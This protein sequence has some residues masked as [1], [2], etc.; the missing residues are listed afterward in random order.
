MGLAFGSRSEE[1]GICLLNMFSMRLEM[2]LAFVFGRIFGVVNLLYKWPSQNFTALP[3]I[4]ML[5][6][7]VI[8]R[9][10]MTKFIGILI[11]FEQLK[12]GSWSP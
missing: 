2:V 7:P 8:F 1:V 6:S 3:E 4:R 9:F 12:I 5:S 10:V 11:L